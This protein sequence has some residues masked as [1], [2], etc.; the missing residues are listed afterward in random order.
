MSTPGTPHK[1]V[2]PKPKSHG[3]HVLTVWGTI[4]CL[5]LAA[6]IGTYI[7][8][9]EAPPPK[10]IVIATGGKAG[11][12][13][14]FALKY[15][16]ALKKEGLT[17]DVLATS[18][19]VENLQFLRD[20]EKGVQVAIVQSGVASADDQEHLQALG[21]LYR[22]PLWVFYGSR[23]ADKDGMGGASAS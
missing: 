11:A 16:A 23:E 12:Y 5:S 18:G 9:V 1:L 2:P 20:N 8:F 17:L 19:S 14:Q 21:S 22:E 3:K 4:I 13:Y 15:A 6:L 10:R 7:L